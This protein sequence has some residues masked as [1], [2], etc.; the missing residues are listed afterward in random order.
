MTSPSPTSPPRP[1]QGRRRIALL[2]AVGA[3]AVLAIAAVAIRSAPSAL[4][5]ASP[6]T[7]AAAADGVQEI[8]VELANGV[9]RPNVLKVKAGVPLRLHVLVRDRHSCST[10]LLVPDLK[11]DFDLPSTG[12]VDL[13]VP[14]ASPGA[15][16]FTCGMKMVKGSIVVE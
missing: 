16:L 6:S 11:L 13:L 7:A 9:Y 10:K 8:T 2:G 5:R 12:T 4:D 14:A 1:R 3:A 15:Y